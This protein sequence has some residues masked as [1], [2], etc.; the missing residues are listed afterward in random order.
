V[1][2]ELWDTE[3][4]RYLGLNTGERG[5]WMANLLFALTMYARDTYTVGGSGLDDPERMRRFNELAHRAATQLRNQVNGVSGLPE[6]VFV[7]MI[8]EEV[9]TLGFGISGLLD[10]LRR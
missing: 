3:I 7:R 1:N 6:E 8:G 5:K 10:D 4:A 2:S 9:Q